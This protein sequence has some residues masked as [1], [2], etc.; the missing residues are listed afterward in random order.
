MTIRSVINDAC[1]PVQKDG[2]PVYCISDKCSL[3]KKTVEHLEAT[4]KHKEENRHKQESIQTEPLLIV[5]AYPPGL[6]ICKN[7]CWFHV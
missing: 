1:L 6:P 7:I 5:I 3:S 4:W 2:H